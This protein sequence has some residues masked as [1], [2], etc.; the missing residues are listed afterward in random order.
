[1]HLADTLIRA[2]LA[3][4]TNTQGEFERVHAVK[5]LPMNDERLEDLR[6]ATQG[7]E[8]MQKLKEVIQVGWPDEK[9]D[10]EAVL[11]PYFIFRN[12]MSVYNGL[13]FRG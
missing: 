13:V 8:V 1:M 3:S 6:R 10:L 2:Y 5:L 11:V 12:E 7:D 4:S 9:N